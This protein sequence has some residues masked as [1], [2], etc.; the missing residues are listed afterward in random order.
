[1]L[2]KVL[3]ILAGLILLLLV[4]A[5]AA[6]AV[7]NARLTRTMDRS[8][9]HDLEVPTDSAAIANGDRLATAYGCRDCHG[10]DLGGQV[11]IDE[12]AFMVLAAPNLTPGEG[13][14]GA[15]TPRDWERAI[16]HGI[17][18]DG[19][20]LLIMPSDSYNRFSD[21]DVGELVAYLRTL[22]PIDRALSRP[23]LGPASRMAALVAADELVPARTLDHDRPHASS[24]PRAATAA[25]GEYLAQGCRGCHGEDLSGAPP[26]MA[27]ELPASNLTPDPETGLGSWSFEDFDRAVRSG[28]RP[29]GS[30]IDASMP[31]K[32]LA[33]LTYDEVL[34]LWR[35]LQ[36]VPPV[37][38]DRNPEGQ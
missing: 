18:P 38:V 26:G 33:A 10:P 2:K 15:Y 4:C 7:G 13:G 1:M 8:I 24:V 12:R 16:R 9:G 6:F 17:S 25:Y 31:W 20:G 23:S 36:T 3:W 22:D 27:S 21:Q 30:V 11:M 5:W 34:A 28:L 35:Y 32:A 37:R 14:T 19:R 29:D